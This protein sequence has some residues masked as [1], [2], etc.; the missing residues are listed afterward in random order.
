[1]SRIKLATP[2]TVYARRNLPCARA[3]RS[4]C[5]PHRKRES[6]H[7]VSG[8]KTLRSRLPYRLR[9]ARHTTDDRMAAHRRLDRRRVVFAR[10]NFVNVHGRRSCWLHHLVRSLPGALR[11]SIVFAILEAVSAFGTAYRFCRGR[12]VGEYSFSILSALES[13]DSGSNSPFVKCSTFL[14]VQ[15]R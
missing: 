13:Q 11:R 12:R 15:S 14:S 7:H 5:H 1:M 10:T 9:L 4:R 2:K 6:P 3:S 8:C